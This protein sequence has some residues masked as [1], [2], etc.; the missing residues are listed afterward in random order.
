MEL[1]RTSVETEKP[2]SRVL[3]SWK[4]TVAVDLEKGEQISDSFNQALVA[5]SVDLG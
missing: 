1:R 4:L 5:K 3:A 2:V